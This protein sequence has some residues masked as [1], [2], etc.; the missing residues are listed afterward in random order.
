L[1]DRFY[2]DFSTS[3]LTRAASSLKISYFVQRGIAA[4]GTKMVR[5]KQNLYGQA[6]GAKGRSTCARILKATA[7]LMEKRPIRE[8]RVAEIGALAGVSSSTFYLYFESVPEAALAVV[9]ALQ[10]ATPE[11]MEILEREWT[12]DTVMQEAKA[13]VRAYFSFWDRHHALLRIR[14]FAAD[15]GD[16]RYLDVRRKSTEPIHLALQDK[17]RQF[18]TQEPGLHHLHPPSTASVLLAML[19]RTAAIIRLPSAHKATRPNQ[20]ESAAFLVASAMIGHV[21]DMGKPAA[22][23][24]KAP[25]KIIPLVEVE[26]VAS[27]K[28]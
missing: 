13:F 28:G 4:S 24:R 12:R 20:I 2:R 5:L 23:K 6:M 8:L 21:G 26:E 11:I 7:E 27:V 10:Q 15:E 18:A 1:P 3:S 17:M 19:E 16:R 22:P 25:K 14:N 9:D